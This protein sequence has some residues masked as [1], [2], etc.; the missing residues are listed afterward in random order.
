L[1][2]WIRKNIYRSGTPPEPFLNLI[3]SVYCFYSDSEAE[4]KKKK[5]KKPKRGRGDSS[6]QESP[7]DS[8]DSAVKR[9][10]KADPA[11][12]VNVVISS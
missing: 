8:E 10:R 6:S 4:K 12:K 9:R 3:K 5:K 2:S 7:S 1:A 11:K